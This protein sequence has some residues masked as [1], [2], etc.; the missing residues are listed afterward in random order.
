MPDRIVSLEYVE[1][2]ESLRHTIVQVSYETS[3]AHSSLF[4]A[5]RWWSNRLANRESARARNC[6]AGVFEFSPGPGISIAGP[7]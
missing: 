7:E 1:S 2:S 6:V 3:I 4:A 5:D